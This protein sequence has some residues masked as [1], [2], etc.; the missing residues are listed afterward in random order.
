MYSHLVKLVCGNIM[1]IT[2]K[3]QGKAVLFSYHTNT[4]AF[5]SPSE[6]NRFFAELHGRKQVVRKAGAEYIYRRKGLL[7]IISH[8]KVDDSVFIVSRENARKVVKFFE[9]WQDKVGVKQFIVLL[10]EGQMKKLCPGC[11]SVRI[12]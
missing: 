6:R 10:G 1:K 11:R 2:I 9:G 7:D 12:E 5:V 8:M 4:K 3:T